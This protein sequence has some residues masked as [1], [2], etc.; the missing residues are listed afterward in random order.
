M[1]FLDGSRKAIYPGAFSRETVMPA[2]VKSMNAAVTDFSGTAVV[3]P[4]G[5]VRLEVCTSSGL[6]K[7]RYCQDFH[8]DPLT[9]A[10]SYQATTVSE[11]FIKG[12]EPTG[13]CDIHGVGDPSL[14][15]NHNYGAEGSKAARSHAIPIQPKQ[16]LLLGQDPY[17]TEQPDFAPK[18]T[19]SS[20]DG[21]AGMNFDQ[22]DQA[23]EDADIIL[24]RP[25]RIEIHEE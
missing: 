10:E 15:E 2:W 1:G 12:S 16:P 6:R 25:R 5:V 3:P 23:D 8:R 18:D 17:G 7:T 20:R 19:R 13:Y 24:D 14:A 11:V 21:G 4:E 22:L 9:G